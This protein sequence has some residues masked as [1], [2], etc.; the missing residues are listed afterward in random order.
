MCTSVLSPPLGVRSRPRHR[1][2]SLSLAL[3]LATPLPSLFRCDPAALAEL[4]L[5]CCAIAAPPAAA[6]VRRRGEGVK[7]PEA[8]GFGWFLY[9]PILSWSNIS[10]PS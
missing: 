8:L 6:A 2:R 5:R 4:E 7:R 9:K 1:S 3:P 10:H